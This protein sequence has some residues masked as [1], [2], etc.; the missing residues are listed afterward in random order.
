MAQ[1]QFYVNA[2]LSEQLELFLFP[3]DYQFLNIKLRWNF[4]RYSFLDYERD[5]KVPSRREFW[6]KRDGYLHAE[7]IK[8]SLLDAN[9][10]E[11]K[12]M[13]AWI[14]FREDKL[15][16]EKAKAKQSE[17]S[18]ANLR[19]AL[20]RLR[21]SRRPALYIT[22]ILFPLL[23]IVSCSFS[24]FS[25]SYDNVHERLAV[26]VTIL[27]TFTAFQS[28]IKGELPETSKMLLIDWYICLAYLLQMLLVMC[29]SLVS[30]LISLDVDVDSVQ[31]IDAASGTVLGLVWVLFSAFYFSLRYQTWLN[32]YGRC[33][34]CCCCRQ[35]NFNDW[36][37][38]ANA[39]IKSWSRQRQ[40][41]FDREHEDGY[42]LL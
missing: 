32:L 4:E 26:S 2:V 33:C 28:L 42:K 39:E 7:P 25:I 34:C 14:D 1:S 31:F 36:K 40:T 15:P 9:K 20:I 29:S 22:N 30:V 23:M 19:F 12:L 35:V 27:L 5:V 11:I 41:G 3:F 17:K 38:R 13:P 21:I 16:S 10:D 18:K 8:I 37:R 6:A 24:I